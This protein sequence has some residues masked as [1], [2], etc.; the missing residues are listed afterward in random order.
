VIPGAAGAEILF[1]SD[2]HLT[3]TT[4]AVTRTL[5]AILIACLLAAATGAAGHLHEHESGTAHDAEHCVIHAALA[6]PTIAGAWSMLLV[7]LGGLVWLLTDLPRRRPHRQSARRLDCR[8]PP[9]NC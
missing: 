6:S 8:G 4:A 7:M 3:D 9:V 1:D 5:A 2:L